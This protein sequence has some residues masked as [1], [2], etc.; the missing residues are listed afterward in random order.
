ML[1]K[2]C[3]IRIRIILSNIKSTIINIL[4]KLSMIT[5]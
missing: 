1:V 3:E 5:R 4:V 2:M